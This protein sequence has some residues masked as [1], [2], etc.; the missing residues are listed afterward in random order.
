MLEI[1]LPS[2]PENPAEYFPKW[3]FSVAGAQNS[4]PSNDHLQP[5]KIT[6]SSVR[7]GYNSKYLHILFAETSWKKTGPQTE[8]T[9]IFLDRRLLKNSS[10]RRIIFCNKKELLKLTSLGELLRGQR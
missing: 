7:S 2:E 4:D 1:N 8:Q 5:L 10:H 6:L 3:V 9:L